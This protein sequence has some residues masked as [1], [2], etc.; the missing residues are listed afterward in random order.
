MNKN[1]LYK[2]VLGTVL[3]EL[4]ITEEKLFGCNSEVCTQG[5]AILIHEL[6]KYLTDAEIEA[7]TPLRR[8]SICQIRNRYAEEGATWTMKQC[9]RAVE[10]ALKK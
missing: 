3:A 1:E 6:A 7:V 9:I 2:R 10:D 4:D 5:R 8:C